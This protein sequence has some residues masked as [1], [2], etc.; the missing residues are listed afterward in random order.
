MENVKSYYIKRLVLKHRSFS[1]DQACPRPPAPPPPPPR[2]RGLVTTPTT[3]VLCMNFSFLRFHLGGRA[4]GGRG[5]GTGQ[6]V[7]SY[8]HTTAQFCGKSFSCAQT[9]SCPED[10]GQLGYSSGC[11][12][13]WWWCGHSWAVRQLVPGAATRLVWRQH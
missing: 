4:G 12:G 6:L 13:W 2:R 11:C 7:G 3:K 5:A 8:Y 9:W 1:V 10:G